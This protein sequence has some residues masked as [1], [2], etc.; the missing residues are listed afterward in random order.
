MN[1]THKTK[2]KNSNMTKDELIVKQQL[3]IEQYK[4]MLK[5]NAGIKHDIIMKFHAMG[6]PLNDNI[7]QFN[8]SQKIWCLDVVSLVEEINT[9]EY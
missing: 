4:Q 5:V 2:L 9:L 6:Q 1:Q 8:E 7:L 3:E